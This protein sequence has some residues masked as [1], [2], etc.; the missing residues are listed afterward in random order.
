MGASCLLCAAGYLLAA[1]AP[2]PAL[3]LVGCALCGLAS[4]ILWPGALSLA[5]GGCPRGG[6]A[7][8]A[9]LALSGDIGC[10]TGPTAVGF[11]AAATGGMNAGLLAAVVFPIVMIAGLVLYRKPAR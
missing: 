10:M 2:N 5:A 11:I 1:R 6:T 7:M 9:L 4:G 3:A 8:F